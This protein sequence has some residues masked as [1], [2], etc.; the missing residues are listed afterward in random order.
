M[1]VIKPYE[2]SSISASGLVIANDSNAAGGKVRGVVLE[3]SPGVNIPIGATV[4][5][6]RYSHD[7]VKYIGPQGEVSVYLV[8]DDEILATPDLKEKTA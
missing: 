5:F 1:C 4:L 6:R 3:V 8:H 7:E 2:A